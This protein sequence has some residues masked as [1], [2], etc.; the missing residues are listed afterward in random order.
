MKSDTHPEIAA[1]YRAMLQELTPS[2]RFAM[3]ARMHTAARRLARAGI[4]AEL[5]PEASERQI[6]EQ[7][8]L[9]W[10]GDLPEPHRSRALAHVLAATPDEPGGR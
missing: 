1:R 2:E 9:R 10:Y 4:L 8:F 3:G 6:R 5:G 7:L